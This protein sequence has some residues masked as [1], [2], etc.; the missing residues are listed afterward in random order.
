MKMKTAC[1]SMQDA[2]KAVLKGKFIE[3]EAYIRKEKKYHI[4]HLSSFLKNLGEKGKHKSKAQR[5]KEMIQ[6]GTESITLKQRKI[7]ENG[8]FKMIN[9][10][11]KAPARLIKHTGHKSQIRARVLWKPCKQQED[12]KVVRGTTLYP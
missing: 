6:T 8:Y 7:I 4:D 12:N 3:P 10:I 11:D 5:A 9:K 1:R 2:S